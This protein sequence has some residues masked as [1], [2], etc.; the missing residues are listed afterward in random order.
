MASTQNSSSVNTTTNRSL[1]RAAVVSKET[2][3]EGIDNVFYAY[4]PKPHYM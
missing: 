4:R 3:C 2:M 1:R